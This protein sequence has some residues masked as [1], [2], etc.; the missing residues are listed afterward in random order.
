MPELAEV[1]YHS[2]QWAPGLGQRV[3]EVRG[4][5]DTRLYRHIPLADLAKALPGRTLEAIETHGKQ[6]RFGFS[7]A[8]FLGLHLGM[9]GA[10]SAGAESEWASPPP[11]AHF[12]LRLSGGTILWFCDY[13]QFGGLRWHEGTGHPPWWPVHRP[14]PF[15]AGFTLEYFRQALAAHPRLALK[16]ALLLQE[17]FPGIGNWMADEILWRARIRPQTLAG[18]IGSPR[19]T[20]L[21]GET[22]AVSRWAMENIGQNYEDPPA[23]WLFPHRWKD[24]GQCPKTGKPLRRA[25]LGGRTTCW[26]PA[27]QR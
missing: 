6:M 7:G 23:T 15:E 20:R 8:A 21:H 19:L 14:Q 24:G 12:Q 25:V 10:L 1:Y 26:S 11:H 5:A 2:R 18:K 22:V 4:R 3:E 17:H 9:T 16:P 13:R 27:W